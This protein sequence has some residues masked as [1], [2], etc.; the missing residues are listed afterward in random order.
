MKP[1]IDDASSAGF[2]GV[3]LSALGERATAAIKERPVLALCTA[4]A[5]GYVIGRLV[6][7]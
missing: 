1:L 3:A 4:L 6:L 2:P 7:R 5:L